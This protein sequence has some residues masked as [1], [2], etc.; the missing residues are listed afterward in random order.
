M[1]PLPFRARRALKEY[2]TVN[3]AFLLLSSAAL[4][5]ADPAPAAPA[6]PA[7]ISTG[8]GCNN[9]GAPAAACCPKTGLLDKIKS[10]LGG[11]RSKSH[12]CGCAP[13]PAPACDTCPKSV[14]D[15][16]NLLDKL[17]A[18]MG[19]KKSCGCAPACDPCA[20][21]PH[22]DAHAPT[23][24]GTPP[25]KEMP[26]PKDPPKVDPKGNVGIPTPLP[27]ITGAAGTSPY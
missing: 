11:L 26:K 13:A 1:C 3:A 10:R 12:D 18:R 23:T 17:R 8:H 7:V 19:A 27:P 20:T 2:R 15:R 9:C 22:H 4:A 25:P 21:A 6:A 24:G 14:A 16:P 5:G